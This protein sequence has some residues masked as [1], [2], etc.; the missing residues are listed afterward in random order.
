[1]TRETEERL[2]AK[3]RYVRPVLI[4]RGRLQAITGGDGATGV[5]IDGVE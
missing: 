3:R 1:M 4:A 2:S 5:T